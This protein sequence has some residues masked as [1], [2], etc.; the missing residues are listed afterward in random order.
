MGT[1]VW[2]LDQGRPRAGTLVRLLH[3]PLRALD[4]IVERSGGAVVRIDLGLF[5]PYLVTRPE[6]VQ[7]VLRDRAANYRRDG[8]MWRPMRRLLGQGIAGEGGTWAE[9]RRL[10]Q[11][12]FTAR[13]VDGLVDAMAEAVNEAAVGA[14]GEPVEAYREMTRIVHRVVRRIFFADRITAGEVDRLGTATTGILAALAS[15]MV[16]PFVPDWVPLPGDATFRRAA[17][18]VDKALV[19]QIRAARERDGAGTDLVTWLSRARDDAGVDL[20]EEQVRDDLV[21]L[22]AAGTESTAVALTWLWVLLDRHPE[23]AGRLRAEVDGVVGGG[24]AGRVHLP[25]LRYTRMVLQELLRLYPPGWLIPRVAAAPDVIGGVPVRAGETVV[26]S[27]YV[28]QRLPQWWDR[29][30]VFDPER[31][32]PERATGRHPYAYLPFGAGPHPCL[33]SHFFTVEAQLVVAALLSRYRPRLADA[34][35]V[36]ARLGASLRP[37]QQVRLVLAP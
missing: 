16:L 31:F 27:P 5:R 7:R 24:P 23:V 1:A 33:G 2:S 19:P 18:T 37:R 13:H 4:E 22:F 34:G 26:V 28:T 14:T 10:V 32:A 25:G 35:P 12:A 9:H 17:R 6:D 20:A 30:A 21:A 11:P 29:P 3:D 8:M 36:T 15:R